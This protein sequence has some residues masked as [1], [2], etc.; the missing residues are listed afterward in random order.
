[1]RIFAALAQRSGTANS[2]RLCLSSILVTILVSSCIWDSKKLDE[3][4]TH[5]RDHVAEYEALVR[6]VEQNPHFDVSIYQSIFP[7]GIE[8]TPFQPPIVEVTPVNFYYVIVFAIGDGTLS[9]SSA[10]KDGEK[11]PGIQ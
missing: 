3:T 8:V 7:E 9:A 2:V 5:F 11:M 10:M 6:N 4:L 1:M